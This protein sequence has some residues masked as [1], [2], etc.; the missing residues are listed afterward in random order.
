MTEKTLKQTVTILNQRGLHARAAAKL[1]QRAGAFHAEI[2]IARGDTSVSATSIMGLMMLAA[3][4]DTVIEIRARGV[5]A[6]EAVAALVRLISD[7]FEE[8][9]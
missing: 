5:D 3:G 9:E 7:R 4:Q 1:V 2:E 6:K 8:D